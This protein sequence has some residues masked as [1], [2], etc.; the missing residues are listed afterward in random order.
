MYDNYPSGLLFI[1]S[2]YNQ[3]PWNREDLV[4]I[5]LSMVRVDYVKSTL[6]SRLVKFAQPNHLCVQIMVD[7]LDGRSIDRL[8]STISLLYD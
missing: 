6:S 3:H 5:Q 2:I 1:S 8:S 7:F 4:H